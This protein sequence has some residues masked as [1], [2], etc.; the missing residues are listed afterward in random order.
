MVLWYWAKGS[1]PYNQFCTQTRISGG[2]LLQD[3]LCSEPDVEK[4]RIIKATL[5]GMLKGSK[6]NDMMECFSVII[7]KSPFKN[8]LRNPLVIKMNPFEE[9]SLVICG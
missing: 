8:D 6:W 4:F 2:T 7:F 9:Y 3:V 5:G 1:I